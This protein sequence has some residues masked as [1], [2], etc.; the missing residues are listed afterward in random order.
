LLRAANQIKDWHEARA[1]EAAKLWLF[2]IAGPGD[3]QKNQDWRAWQGKVSDL[4]VKAASAP[5]HDNDPVPDAP[6]YTFA[7]LFRLGSIVRAREDWD[8][9]RVRLERLRDIS[10]ALGL[11]G[12]VPDKPPVLIIPRTP[13]FT[14]S[15][16]SEKLQALQK[17]YPRFEQDFA[18]TGLPDTVA[19]EVS[20]AARTQFQLLLEP[21]REEVLRQLRRAGP[22]GG[23]T[24]A[25][26]SNLL[27][28]M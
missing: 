17:S 21:G 14:L 16:A 2:S 28:S 5:A 1:R 23:E 15:Q 4:F 24:P 27:K 3:G 22:E 11:G 19:G 18:L 20:Q 26:W 6:S 8:R 13:S 10:A 25:R 7:S 12:P 9:A